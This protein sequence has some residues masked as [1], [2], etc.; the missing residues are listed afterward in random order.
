MNNSGRNG[1]VPMLI[2]VVACA[3]IVLAIVTWIFKD[4]LV[5]L[6]VA[7]GVHSIIVVL[8]V[9]ALIAIIFLA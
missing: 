5:P 1:M 7:F 4:F 3:A 8:L 9:I 6:G 2:V